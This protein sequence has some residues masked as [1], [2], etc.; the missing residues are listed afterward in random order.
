MRV[1]DRANREL[2]QPWIQR[3]QFALRLAQRRVEACLVVLVERRKID[4]FDRR[5][6]LLLRVRPT[7]LVRRNHRTR[8]QDFH[9]QHRRIRPASGRFNGQLSVMKLRLDLR[10]IDSHGDQKFLPGLRAS[11]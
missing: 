5:V 4:G 7:F 6:E 11:P 10:S 3:L 8:R 9:S 2:F 1:P